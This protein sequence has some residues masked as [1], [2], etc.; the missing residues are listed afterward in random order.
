MSEPLEVYSLADVSDMIPMGTA[1]GSFYAGGEKQHPNVIDNHV[2]TSDVVGTDVL[3]STLRGLQDMQA[4][5]ERKGAD[6][7]ALQNAE[8]ILACQKELRDADGLSVAAL[9]TGASKLCVLYNK[10]GTKC[11]KGG[12]YDLASNLFARCMKLTDADT[13]AMYFAQSDHLRTSLRST[14]LN[15]IGCMERRRGR[16]DAALQRLRECSA[17]ENHSSPATNLNIS[18]ILTQLGRHAEAVGTARRAI[19]LLNNKQEKTQED[20]SLLVI[21]Y[22]NLAMAQ[23]CSPSADDRADAKASYAA[24]V[25]TATRTLGEAHPTTVSVIKSLQRAHRQAKKARQKR[26]PP[27]PQQPQPQSASQVQALQERRRSRTHKPDVLAQLPTAQA[28]TLPNIS[29]LSSAVAAPCSPQVLGEMMTA[30]KLQEE[31]NPGYTGETGMIL[32]DQSKPSRPRADSNAA[33][34]LLGVGGGS[35]LN[36]SSAAA[37]QQQHGGAKGSTGRV[38]KRGKRGKKA[39]HAPLG[40]AR[41]Q[42]QQP[43]TQP[44]GSVLGPTSVAATADHPVQPQQPPQ[45]P[46]PAKER[47]VVRKVDSFVRPPQK[48]PPQAAPPLPPQHQPQPPQAQPQPPASSSGRPNNNNNKEPKPPG[49]PP[50]QERAPRSQP[51]PPLEAVSSQQAAAASKGG[52][53]EERA[54]EKD[55]EKE[56]RTDEKTKEKAV[57]RGVK[58]KRKPEQGATAA[59]SAAAP[60]PPAPPPEALAD[61][62]RRGRGMEDAREEDKRKEDAVAYMHQLLLKLLREE[63]VYEQQFQAALR[64]QCMVRCSGAHATVEQL[65]ELR[66]K[67]QSM[68]LYRENDSAKIVTRFIRQLAVANISRRKHAR[69]AQVELDRRNRAAVSIQR[70]SRGWLARRRT[71]W[72]RTYYQRVNWCT[73]TLQCFFRRI[74]ALKDARRRKAAAVVAWQTKL[75]E[76]RLSSLATKVQKVYRGYRARVATSALRG[77]IKRQIALDGD[78]LRQHAATRISV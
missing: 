22:H 26:R 9:E 12:K 32:A 43:Q 10:I 71:K 76:E 31:L 39:S 19:G 73:L 59:V 49:Q 41:Q 17:L 14:T 51:Q 40:V 69:V 6:I 34:G 55:A 46:P 18:A 53:D 16:N 78:S 30:E 2:G 72:L 24:A 35:L 74:R 38:G 21:A 54:K 23:E 27:Q 50:P 65:K 67:E 68:R 58:K 3:L 15:N 11:F 37:A 61:G 60:A 66:H 29:P 48:A 8:R 52:V 47:H 25:D 64:I 20:C 56:R 28:P 33:A 62:R 4:G 63:D 57:D 70:G 5:L 1:P 44:P 42:Q 7:E 13:G 77:R 36:L 45:Q 75:S